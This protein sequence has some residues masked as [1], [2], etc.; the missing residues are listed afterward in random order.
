MS[1][2]IQAALAM[3]HSG[4]AIS[5]G[6]GNHI[7]QLAEAIASSTLTDL[8]IC[9][10][11]EATVATCRTLS[12]T[13]DQSLTATDLAFDG[14]DQVTAQ[15]DALK[16]GGAIFTYEKRNAM[17]TKQFVLLVGAERYVPE[18]D[19]QVPLTV[20]ALDVAIPLVQQ[21][22][23]VFHTTATLRDASN[24]MGLTRT[25]DGN[26]VIDVTLPEGADVFDFAHRFEQLP[27]VVATS[28]FSGLVHTIL[29]ETADGDVQQLERTH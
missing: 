13:V 1:K 3:I 26:V 14:C 23:D 4:M 25:R 7:K 11:S 15:F 28:L 21:V 6:G 29:L 19:R 5:L 9:S 22:A 2:Q 10:P 17:L 12:L 8:R 24:Y 20:E 27:G 18:F 16:S